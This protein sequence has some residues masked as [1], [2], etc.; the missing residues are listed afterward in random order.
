MI[1]TSDLGQRNPS[2]NATRALDEALLSLV[3]V[4]DVPNRIEILN[5][6]H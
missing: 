1:E 5:R 3:E 4:D 2:V 6:A